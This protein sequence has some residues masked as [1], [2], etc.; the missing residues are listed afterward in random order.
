MDVCQWAKIRPIK[1]NAPKMLFDDIF[2]V[3][4]ELYN[5]KLSIKDA[6]W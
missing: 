6:I 4:T 2:G 3:Y 1:L 5:Y